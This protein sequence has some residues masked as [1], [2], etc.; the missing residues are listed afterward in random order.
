MT[1]VYKYENGEFKEE[2]TYHNLMSGFTPRTKSIVIWSGI[3]IGV[4][5]IYKLLERR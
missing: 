2:K 5:V 4:I 3:A 1:E